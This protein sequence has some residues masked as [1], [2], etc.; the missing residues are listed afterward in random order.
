MP[1]RVVTR[2]EM[3]ENEPDTYPPSSGH[4]FSARPDAFSTGRAALRLE[5]TAG[6]DRVRD[7]RMAR[8]YSNSI[9]RLRA[10]CVVRVHEGGVYE[11]IVSN[12]CFR[13]TRADTV[14]PAT[15]GEGPFS[16][17]L[18]SPRTSWT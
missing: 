18:C 9:D 17:V 14:Q 4:G 1:R 3:R 5:K 13:H 10:Y 6:N 2:L 12:D 7:I 8:T 16:N 11:Y 15:V